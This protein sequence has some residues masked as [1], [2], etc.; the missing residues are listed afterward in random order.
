M[1][2]GKT[3]N[4][5]I[6]GLWIKMKWHLSRGKHEVGFTVYKGVVISRGRILVRGLLKPYGRNR[7]KKYSN[8]LTAWMQLPTHYRCS[9]INS[10]NLRAKKNAKFYFLIAM[11]PKFHAFR[12]VMPCH[13]ASISP[14]FPNLKRLPAQGQ[15]CSGPWA[16]FVW[17]RR[18]DNPSTRRRILSQKHRVMS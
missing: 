15:P 8:L 6:V 2:V 11:L 4:Y 9:P 16:T 14:R 18:K 1:G 7:E 5:I 13:W 3:Y 17:R 12:N 10:P